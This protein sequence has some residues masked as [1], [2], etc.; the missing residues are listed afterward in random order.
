[1]AQQLHAAGQSV[2]LLA[3][4]DMGVREYQRLDV[5]TGLVALAEK[6][7]RWLH[8]FPRLQPHE[9]HAQLRERLRRWLTPRQIDT[10]SG[11]AAARLSSAYQL[12]PYPG[13]VTVFWAEDVPRPLAGRRDP[14]EGWAELAAGL[15]IIPV[16]GDH[17]L[18]LTEPRVHV[19][20]E[21]VRTCLVR[22]QSDHRTPSS[23]SMRVAALA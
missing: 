20:G 10:V 21:A 22:A 16:P 12:R 11:D 19:L 8:V 17:V 13:R 14:R 9:R 3:M 1:M 2:D 6:A 4:L 7:H 23:A 18:M 5:R 15:E